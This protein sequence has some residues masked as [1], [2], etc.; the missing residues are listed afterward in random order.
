V[1]NNK[2][3]K[4]G[5]QNT[6]GMKS[7]GPASTERVHAQKLAELGSSSTTT[8]AA[9]RRCVGLG[10][11]GCHG[12]AVIREIAGFIDSTKKEFGRKAPPARPTAQQTVP[13]PGVVRGC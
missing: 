1:L 7:L 2:P 13:G 8:T 12:M 4:K 3:Q 5:A 11:A 6:P 10:W 9:S